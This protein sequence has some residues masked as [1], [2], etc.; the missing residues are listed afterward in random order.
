MRFRR[1]TPLQRLTDAA[2]AY[3]RAKQGD[4][5]PEARAAAVACLAGRGVVC[6]TVA[7]GSRGVLVGA[8]AVPNEGESVELCQ[9][10]VTG[11][12]AGAGLR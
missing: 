2:L 4:I 8:R 10:L 7:A 1:Q 6:V 3:L 12:P 5:P 11:N 9:E